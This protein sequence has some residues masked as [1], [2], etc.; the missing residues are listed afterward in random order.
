MHLEHCI[1]DRTVLSTGAGTGAG[2]NR[3]HDMMLIIM[4][5]IGYLQL[6]EVVVK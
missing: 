2:T 3:F 1:C 4:I 5:S 6:H